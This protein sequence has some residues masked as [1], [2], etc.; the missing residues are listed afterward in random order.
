MRR[1][2][3]PGITAV[4]LAALMLGM[5]P[6]SALAGKQQNPEQSITAQA[7]KGTAAPK[8][9]PAPATTLSPGDTLDLNTATAM[10]FEAIAGIGPKRAQA[11]VSYRDANGP[12]QHKEDLMN[13]PGI[14]KGIYTKAEPWLRVD[15]T[16]IRRFPGKVQRKQ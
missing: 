3:V 7:P 1:Y 6:G 9:T 13:V 8:V 4:T 11:I 15:D 5:F 12:F 14:G 10:E 2:H 16:T